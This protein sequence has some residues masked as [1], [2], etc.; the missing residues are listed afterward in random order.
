V[1]MGMNVYSFVGQICGLH[2]CT[3]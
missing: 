2:L 1:F 3:F